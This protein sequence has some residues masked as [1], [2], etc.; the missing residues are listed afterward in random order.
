MEQAKN[1]KKSKISKQQ[2]QYLISILIMLGVT[3]LAVYYVLK[4]NIVETF[5]TLSSANV[6]YIMLMVVIIIISYI[7]EG[8]VLTIFAKSYKRKY[9]HYQGVLNG[10][11][12]SFFSSITPFSSGG[13]F[14]QAYTFTKQGIKAPNAAS[15]LV[16]L[17]IVSQTSIVI[18]GILAMS[19]GY[20]STIV[21]MNDIT[22]W[23]W[24]ISPIAFSSIGFVI[25]CLSLGF[26]FFMSYSKHLHH[27]ILNTCINI[28]A[29]FHMIREPEKT[30]TH[31]AAQVAT[32]R[33]ELSRLLKNFWVLLLTILLEFFKFSCWH[34]MPYFAGLALGANMG[35]KFFQCIWSN[36]YLQMITSF[37]PL[38]GGSGSA[39]A[40]FQ[41]LFYSIYNN[42]AITS[43]ANLLC[44]G[45][46]FYFTLFTGFIV[47]IFYKGSPKTKVTQY[48]NRETFVDLQVLYL[49]ENKAINLKD[50]VIDQDNQ[51]ADLAQTSTLSLDKKS[52][53]GRK[54]R[55]W[56][57]SKFIKNFHWKD[58]NFAS[59]DD[60]KNS[61]ENIKKSLILQ[62]KDIY[63]EDDEMTKISKRYLKDV[64]NDI[65]S[66]AAEEGLTTVR[67]T[68]LEKAIQADLEAIKAS[69]RKKALRLQKRH[70]R[71]QRKKQAKMAKKEKKWS[72][73]EK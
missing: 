20:S 52:I 63:E 34:V 47:F 33:I 46:T 39:E 9:R 28:G 54:K 5:S 21:N 22:I 60:I 68:E 50:V 18:M 56:P 29:K 66:I 7:I 41:I 25:N 67:D 53:K 73:S 36:S 70:E 6:Y 27:F 61:F 45:I 51:K 64:Y 26:L 14:V 24:T 13:Q 40:G 65:K 16:M 69:D 23:G 4:D 55:N 15:I 72:D 11:I 1:Q 37:I 58:S 59:P 49:A 3:I 42:S 30:R 38:P 10:L 57:W 2:I 12:G 35:G 62:Q 32:F 31:L 8:S 44:R 17:F 43:A 48:N 71:H 19:I